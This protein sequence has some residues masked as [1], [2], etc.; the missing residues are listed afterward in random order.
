MPMC[1]NAVNMRLIYLSF[2]ACFLLIAAGCAQQ[3]TSDSQ[4]YASDEGSSRF[5]V[6]RSSSDQATGITPEGSLT[7][8]GAMIYGRAQNGGS[9]G[10]GV[11]FSLVPEGAV[12]TVLHNFGGT[13]D[14]GYPRHDAMILE[15]NELYGMVMGDGNTDLGA[16][17]THDKNGNNYKVLHSFKGGAQDGNRPHSCPRLNP[18]DGMLYGITELGGA[19]DVGTLFRINTDGTG[20]Q[21]LHSFST[22]TEGSNSHG[23]VTFNGTILYAMALKGGANG[24]GTVFSFNTADN[25]YKVVHTFAGSPDDGASPEHCNTLLINDRLYGTTTK[26]GASD[27][28]AIWSMRTDGTDF[29]LLYSFKGSSYGSCPLGSLMYD[30]SSATFYG[31]TSGKNVGEATLYSLT[32]S[33]VYTTLHT[34]DSSLTCIDNVILLNG[35]LWGMARS[36]NSSSSDWIIFSYRL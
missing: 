3:Y 30:S 35:Y 25:S 16:V 33:G 34:F 9:Y 5:T 12:Y 28:G 32:M 23:A 17:F 15:G 11:T 29:R 21:L 14:A 36:N 2:L 1:K 8:D 31:L 10:G 18:A 13:G 26:G 27:Y 24:K 6:V 22:D 19:N 4:V 7:T 20:F